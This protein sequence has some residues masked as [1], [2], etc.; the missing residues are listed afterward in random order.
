MVIERGQVWWA[1]LPIPA[2][3]GPGFDRPVLVIQADSFNRSKIQTV[4][5]AAMTSNLQRARSPG[6]VLVPRKASG[7]P[8]DSVVN[9][10]QIMSLDQSL[11]RRKVQRLRDAEMRKV[12]EGLRMVLSL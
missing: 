7:L 3:S 10:S 8:R 9:V 12:D 1:A 6:N 5:V 4:I 2:G 11:L